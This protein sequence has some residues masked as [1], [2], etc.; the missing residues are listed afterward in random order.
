MQFLMAHFIAPKGCSRSS[1]YRRVKKSVIHSIETVIANQHVLEINPNAIPIDNSSPTTNENAGVC[2][3]IPADAASNHIHPNANGLNIPVSPPQMI[4]TDSEYSSQRSDVE[5]KD[6]DSSENS[7]HEELGGSDS[8]VPWTA[9][10][11]EWAVHENVSTSAVRSLLTMLKPILPELP[12]DPR[13]LLKTPTSYKLKNVTGSSGIPGCY[14]HFGISSGIDVMPQP[15]R[16]LGIQNFFQD[17]DLVKNA[18][19]K[20]SM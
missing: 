5:A 2:F 13:T 10:L 9:R 12:L 1:V 19:K 18:P 15:V 6:S 17:I 20:G 11:A 14:Y 7:D 8:N 4:S 16:I 3:S